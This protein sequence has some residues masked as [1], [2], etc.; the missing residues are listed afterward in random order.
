MQNEKGKSKDR[1][2]LPPYLA[3]YPHSF[4]HLA[5]CILHFSFVIS[6]QERCTGTN[7]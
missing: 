7:E 3:L 2:T 6:P 1:H 4:L 5:F